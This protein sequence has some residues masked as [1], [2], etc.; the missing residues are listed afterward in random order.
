MARW[1]AITTG[2]AMSRELFTPRCHTSGHRPR[3]ISAVV[4]SLLL[5]AAVAGCSAAAPPRSTT[6]TTPSSPPT[7]VAPSASGTT[8]TP[9][10]T[11]TSGTTQPTTATTVPRTTTT[12]PPATT[13]AAPGPINT[14]VEVY[15]NCQTPS[16]APSE[17]VLSCADYGTLWVDLHWTRWTAS[18]A[19]AVGILEYKICKPNCAVGSTGRLRN[20]QITLSDPVRSGAGV[21]VFSQI[22]EV[23]EPPGFETGP[24]H[25][26]PQPLPTVPD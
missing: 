18:L 22:Q 20:D 1:S 8:S 2:A 11:S 26:G 7:T 6:T 23:P 12:R 15:A 21:M 10:T 13:A 4:A 5:P 14:H 9:G 19:T 24:Y 17:L 3:R 25:G 16:V